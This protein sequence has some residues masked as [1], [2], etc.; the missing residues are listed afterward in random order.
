MKKKVF[1]GKIIIEKMS[2]IDNQFKNAHWSTNITNSELLFTNFVL[3]GSPQ[4]NK[5][6]RVNEVQFTFIS[7]NF[8][9]V[10]GLY[11]NLYWCCKL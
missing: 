11:T 9:N 4:N 1:V 8:L 5:Y 7:T 10:G 2:D 3:S 6:I